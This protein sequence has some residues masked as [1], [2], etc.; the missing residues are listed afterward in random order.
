MHIYIH[1]CIH[2]HTYIYTYIHIHTHAYIRTC[3]Q[4]WTCIHTNIRAHKHT[5]IHT[6]HTHIHTRT[7][8]VVEDAS[9]ALERRHTVIISTSNIR[10]LVWLVHLWWMSDDDSFLL[11]AMSCSNRDGA[12]YSPATRYLMD[13][14]IQS[15]N[16][17]NVES[18]LVTWLNPAQQARKHTVVHT[19]VHVHVHTL[20]T[21][22]RARAAKVIQLMVL[23]RTER[24][25]MPASRSCSTVNT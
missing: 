11:A 25:I 19:P 6:V 4:T 15:S 23:Q 16:W 10:L 8:T 3:T 12:W 1:T 9:T 20:H 17:L 2:T 18:I 5:N 21:H 7:C 22:T 13:A 14:V 24:I